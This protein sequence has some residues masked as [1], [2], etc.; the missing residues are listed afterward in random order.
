MTPSQKHFDKE[1]FLLNSANTEFKTGHSHDV[2]K[3]EL[4]DAQEC[5][6]LTSLLLQSVSVCSIDHSK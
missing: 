5:Q 1:S 4:I 2:R 3:F 6:I